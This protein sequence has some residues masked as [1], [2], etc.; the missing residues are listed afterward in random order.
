MGRCVT[1]LTSKGMAKLDEA[2]PLWF[3]AQK[4]FEEVIEVDQAESIR[5]A[6]DAI[7]DH[8]TDALAPIGVDGGA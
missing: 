4:N 6:M 8:R 1:A 7:S 3:H 2:R 5:S